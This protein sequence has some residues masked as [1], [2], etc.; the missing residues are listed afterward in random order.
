[1]ELALEKLALVL[2]SRWVGELALAVVPAV[3]R[4]PFVVASRIKSHFP[5]QIF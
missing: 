5:I 3:L 2:H 1:V 4:L